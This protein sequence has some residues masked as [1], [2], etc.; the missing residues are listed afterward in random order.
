MQKPWYWL[1]GLIVAFVI[2]VLI[3]AWR[4]QTRDIAVIKEAVRENVEE[5]AK[6]ESR[7]E[8]VLAAR[9]ATDVELTVADER[10]FQ[11]VV[12]RHRG[13]VVLV[14]FWA[15]WCQ[16]CVQHFPQTVEL[17]DRERSA[18]LA[19]VTLNFD[20]LDNAPAVKQFLK[21]VRAG[22]LDNLQSSYDGVGT[23]APKAFDFEGVLP[24]YRLYDRNGKLRY[25]W[26]EPP[27]DLESKVAE[28][29]QEKVAP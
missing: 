8:K 28:L 29:L 26:D 24:H 10:Q 23:E 11:Q 15:T 21:K 6:A 25:R 5:I 1:G 3:V 27:P 2:V 9:S 4:T 17:F 19:A 20:A 7:D 13:E 18:G 12:D 22:A 16:T 14:D